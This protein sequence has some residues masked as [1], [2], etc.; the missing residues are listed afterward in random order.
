MLFNGKKDSILNFSRTHDI[1]EEIAAKEVI[2][3]INCTNK[4]LATLSV[5][6]DNR[7]AEPHPGH[8]NFVVI[9]QEKQEKGYF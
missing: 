7:S 1:E 4:M 5:S 6:D 8:N 9:N 3:T 2:L